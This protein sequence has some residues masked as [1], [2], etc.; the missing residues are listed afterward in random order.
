MLNSLTCYILF[1]L[2]N[3]HL[4]KFLL[5]GICC[6]KKNKKQKKT[7]MFLALPLPLQSRLSE[8]PEKLHPGLK[9]C[10]LHQIKHNSQPLGCAFFSVDILL[11]PTM[12]LRFVMDGKWSIEKIQKELLFTCCPCLVRKLCLCTVLGRWRALFHNASLRLI[13]SND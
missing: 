10:F 11:S 7:P 13:F 2:I 1:S 9:S 3:S 4:L 8:L 6:K 5:P 12:A